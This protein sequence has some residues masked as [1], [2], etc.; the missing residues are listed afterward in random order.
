MKEGEKQS[1]VC[2]HQYTTRKIWQQVAAITHCRQQQ[3]QKQ[4]NDVQKVPRGK[5]LLKICRFK[6]REINDCVKKEWQKKR[7]TS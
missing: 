2:N 7:C 1:P 5:K 3:Q 6:R 4:H